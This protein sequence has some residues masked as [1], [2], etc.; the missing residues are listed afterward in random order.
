MTDEIKFKWVI[1]GYTNLFKSL[2]NMAVL[3]VMYNGTLVRSLGAY[4]TRGDIVYEKVTYVT[5][6]I[7]IGW[8]VADH[9][10]TVTFL[11]DKIVNASTETQSDQDANQYIVRKGEKDIEYNLCGQYCV[12]AIL[13]KSIDETLNKVQSDDPA[14]F[15]R[16]F[17]RSGNNGRT[18]IQDL[19]RVHKM[20]SPSSKYELLYDLLRDKVRSYVLSPGRMIE[21]IKDYD[22]I[23]GI[24]ISNVSGKPKQTGTLH[25]VWLLDIKVTG[26]NMGVVTFY[27]PFRDRHQTCSWDELYVSMGVPAGLCIKKQDLTF[28]E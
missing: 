16:M 15:R 20:F 7:L 19:M 22:V 21:I 27:N 5:S 18:S 10:E 2:E 6:Q 4:E 13:G 25:W 12:S 9:I 23:V 14:F 24:K 3:S 8:V 11:S 28:V 17:S 1:P 26:V